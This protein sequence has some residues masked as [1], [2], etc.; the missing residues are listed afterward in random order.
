MSTEYEMNVH[1][2]VMSNFKKIELL[3]D[4]SIPDYAIITNIGESHIEYLGTRAGIAEA[5]LEITYGMDSSGTLIVD[6]DESLLQSI[7]KPDKVIKCGLGEEND[8]IIHDISLKEQYTQF[9]VDHDKSDYC[10]PLLGK[11]HA[12]NATFAITLAKALGISIEKDRKSV[13]KGKNVNKRR[14]G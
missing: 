12:K 1:E 9:K 10:I 8:V 3:S 14:R 7:Q 2:I 13:V 4:I 11:H 5:K 6:G